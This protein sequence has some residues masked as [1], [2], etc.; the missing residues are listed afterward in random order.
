MYFGINYV[1]IFRILKMF[2]A[3]QINKFPWRNSYNT[4]A[5]SVVIFDGND[6]TQISS[7]VNIS[8]F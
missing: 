2:P 4:V 6:I 5:C 7:A 8:N 3:D 1:M